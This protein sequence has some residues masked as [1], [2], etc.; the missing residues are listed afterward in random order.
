MPGKVK[1]FYELTVASSPHI[2]SPSRTW[3]IMGNVLLALLPALVWAVIV[4][5]FRVLTVAAVSVAGCVFFEWA[6]RKIRKQDCTVGDLSAAVT[7]LLLALTCPVTIPYW[8]ILVG[9][10]FAIVVVKQLFGGIGK[11]FVNPALAARAFLFSWPVDM[12]TWAAP[13]TKPGVIS[14]ADAVTSATPLNSLHTGQLPAESLLDL[15]L[16]KTAGSMGEIS[17]LLLL[18][19]GLYLVIRRIISLRIPLAFLGTVAFLTFLFPQGND[20]LPWMEYQ[21]LSGGLML[22]AWFMA[23]DYVTSPVTGWGKILF[24]IGCGAITVF[25]RYFGAYAEGVSYAILVMNLCVVLLD[26]VGRPKR[27][28]VEK[29]EGGK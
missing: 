14:A 13:W 3:K 16:G 28:G 23:T 11:N 8:I 17:A 20:R 19:G 5:G 29:K 22:G 21:L 9:D 12:T 15:F 6:F 26:R 10:F 24:G 25:I 18:I 2:H 27:F 4:F 1:Y 7:G